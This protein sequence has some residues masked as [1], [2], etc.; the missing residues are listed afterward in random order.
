MK[1]LR[2]I[3]I[4]I[5]GL[6]PGLDAG[7]LEAVGLPTNAPARIELRDQFDLP[8]ELTFPTTN[9]TLLTIADKKGSAQVEAWIEALKP[10]FSNRIVIRGI[11]DVRGAPVIMH[12]RIRKAFQESRKHPVMID[13]TG[14]VCALFGYKKGEA[15]I[16]LMDRSGRIE[17]R[18]TGVATASTVAKASAVLD[19]MLSAVPEPKPKTPH[20]HEQ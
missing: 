5:I 2:S 10:R 4:A 6:F 13:W 3:L 1:I 17:A 11:A 14:N 7:A 15:N 20:A 19:K 16:L 12:G 8:Q 18:Y 9:V